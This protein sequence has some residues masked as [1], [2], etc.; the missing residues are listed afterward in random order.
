MT[1][2]TILS[3]LGM[4]G[5]VVIEDTA[6]RWNIT[7]PPSE[8]ANFTFGS[9]TSV[10]LVGDWNGDGIEGIGAYEAGSG[11]FY[12]RQTATGGDA[13][14]S[15]QYGAFNLTPI[16][17]Y[18]E[19]ETP[20]YD[21]IG[22]IQ[23]N[24]VYLDKNISSGNAEIATTIDNIICFSPLIKQ[25][26]YILPSYTHSRSSFSVY[27]THPYYYDGTFRSLTDKI[28]SISDLGID[29]IYL[30]PIWKRRDESVLWDVYSIMDYYNIDSVYGTP[31]EL[32][33]LVNTV[34]L[35]GMKILFDLVTVFATIGSIVYNNNWTLNISTTNLQSIATTNGW[36]LHYTTANGLNIVYA[37]QQLQSDGSYIYDF[38]G[39]II[40]S[41]V[42]AFTYPS[43]WGPAVDR[44][45]P[46]VIDYFTEVAKYY[47]REDT[48][49][50]DGWR[51][52]VP[53]YSYNSIVFP[54]NH[55]AVNLLT[56]VINAV[57]TIKPN[58]IFIS[59]PTVP[60]GVSVD[61]EYLYMPF[62]GIMSGVIGNIITSYQLVSRLLTMTT[63]TPLYVLESHDLPRLNTAYPLYDKNFIVLISTFYGSPFIQA[64]QEI[65]ATNTWMVNAQVDWL[66]GNDL[67]RNF[68]K[69]VLTIR[70]SSNAIKYGFVEDIWKS[71]D[72]IY[73]YS[74]IYGEDKVVVLLNFRET[75]TTSVLNTPFKN[76]DIIVDQLSGE[77]FDVTDPTNFGISVP[78]YN[79]RILMIPQ[80]SQAGFGLVGMFLVSGLVI[81]ATYSQAQKNTLIANNK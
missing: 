33:D 28:P 29:V 14:I 9:P 13:E 47:V 56:S 46:Q 62:T 58:A 48:Y 74:T 68:Y 3:R 49:N 7:A 72:N 60:V 64:G 26:T 43:P 4:T 40:G 21:G 11:Y 35:Y 18:D 15:V 51:I 39:A 61:T 53:G 23:G 22:I 16:S 69:K 52:D 79:S 24:T 77:T 66:N 55:S 12:L 38:Y 45:D 65:G 32:K 20:K 71:G 57:K 34:H 8:V 17:W 78:A 80:P 25:C 70:N 59:E 37:G 36:T 27:E 10:P 5:T 1:T 30:M 44:S 76:G 81:G 42:V 6:L 73:A 67:L 19:S 41:N 63:R 75:Q 50:I 2:W 31:Q 54:G